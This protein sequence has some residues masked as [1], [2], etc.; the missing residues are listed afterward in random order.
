MDN[1]A[2]AIDR[3]RFAELQGQLAQ[4]QNDLVQNEDEVDRIQ[5]V[6]DNLD[7]RFYAA[8]QNFRFAR[9]TYDVDKYDYEEALANEGSNVE[10]LDQRRF[11]L[12]YI[13]FD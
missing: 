12:K 2:G 11:D 13:P 3:T 5:G 1:A 10:S 7:A 9:A 8:D 6:L 4:A